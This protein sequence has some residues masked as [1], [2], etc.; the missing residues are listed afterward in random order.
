MDVDRRRSGRR[1]SMQP[2]VGCS[3]KSDAGQTKVCDC[4]YHRAL[5]SD[6]IAHHLE[7]ETTKGK[8]T[9]KAV[10]WIHF[11]HG[12]VGVDVVHRTCDNFG[13]SKC[14]CR[15]IFAKVPKCPKCWPTHALL[16]TTQSDTI[17][18]II[19]YK[20]KTTWVLF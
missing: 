9:S 5:Q 15:R 11:R 17:L 1:V 7:N 18:R 16:Q 3:P 12:A 4:H 20:V 14:Q 6:T 2:R 19:Q 10:Q 13:I 8:V